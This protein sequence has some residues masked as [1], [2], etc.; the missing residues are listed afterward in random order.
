MVDECLYCRIYL[1]EECVIEGCCS[2]NCSK[3]SRKIKTYRDEL[4]IFC[5]YCKYIISKYYNAYYYGDEDDDC[6][7][8]MINIDNGKCHYCNIPIKNKYNNI[9]IL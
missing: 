5:I 6:E 4:Y 3:L 8:W 7:S 1:N 9:N 2:E